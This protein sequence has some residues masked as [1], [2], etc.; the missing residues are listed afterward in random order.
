MGQTSCHGFGS[1]RGIS[2]FSFGVK[3]M[4][5]AD[6]VKP[7][8]LDMPMY[9]LP[10]PQDRKNMKACLDHDRASWYFGIIVTRII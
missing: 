10:F 1:A 2:D 3:V 4:L 7:E 6:G 9:F 8:S 5:K